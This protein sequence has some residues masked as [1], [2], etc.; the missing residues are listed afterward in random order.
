MT[1]PS[2]AVRKVYLYLGRVMPCCLTDTSIHGEANLP[3]S[4]ANNGSL[5]SAIILA[6]TAD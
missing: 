6:C 2:D 5:R 1:C 3:S 4:R